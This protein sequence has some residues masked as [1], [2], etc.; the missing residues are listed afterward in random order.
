MRMVHYY[1]ALAGVLAPALALTLV[2]GLSFDGPGRHG[3]IGFFTA[4]LC[5][6]LHTLLILFMLVSGRVL[7]AAMQSR[8]L[9]A[10]FLAELNVFFAQRADYPLAL[11]AALSA[12]AAAVLGHGR[13]VGVPTAVHALVGLGALLL[14]G[15]GVTRGVAALRRNQ[16]LL[17]RAAAELDQLDAAGAPLRNAAEPAWSFG[18]AGRWLVFAASAWG[19]YLYWALVVWRGDFGAVS[20][21]LPAACACGSALGLAQAWRRRAAAG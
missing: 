6:A 18:P 4:L 12:A 13:F 5:V 1:L 21:L 10:V 9:P 8:D 7:R 2:T 17:D 11:L 20:P 16:R 19:P 3:L 15:W 14:N